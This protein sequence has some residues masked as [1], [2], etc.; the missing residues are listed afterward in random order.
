MFRPQPRRWYSD[1]RSNARHPY[2]VTGG[3]THQRIGAG[4]SLAHHASTPASSSSTKSAFR[5][6]CDQRR[7]SLGCEHMGTKENRGEYLAEQPTNACFKSWNHRGCD[8]FGNVAIRMGQLGTRTS[9]SCDCGGADSCER[10]A[11]RASSGV[12][13]KHRTSA[14]AGSSNGAV[15]TRKPGA[16]CSPL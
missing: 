10:H 5:T 4:C 1:R 6:R 8:L 11:T 16:D 14:V 13:W 12:A 3:K 2:D 15:P 9:A 7:G